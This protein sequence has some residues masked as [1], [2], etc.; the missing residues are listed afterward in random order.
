MWIG[1][2]LGVAIM[3]PIVAVFGLLVYAAN[4]ASPFK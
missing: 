4:R 3:L 1:I 2:L